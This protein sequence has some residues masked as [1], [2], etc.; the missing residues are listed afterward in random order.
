MIHHH[1]ERPVHM[2]PLP[3]R[4]CLLALCAA[5]VVAGTDMY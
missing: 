5:V 1:P 2:P 4:H 3:R